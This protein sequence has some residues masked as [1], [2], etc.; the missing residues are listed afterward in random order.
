[1]LLATL[2]NVN[3]TQ[4]GCLSLVFPIGCFQAFSPSETSLSGTEVEFKV[5]EYSPLCQIKWFVKVRPDLQ[6]ESIFFIR[7]T[8]VEK[9]DEH[10]G[11]L[12]LL[13]VCNCVTRTEGAGCQRRLYFRM[14]I[15]TALV[16]AQTW[17]AFWGM[18]VCF[19]GRYKT[20]VPVCL[21]TKCYHT[22]NNRLCSAADSLYKSGANYWIPPCLHF[23]L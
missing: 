8:D 12:T 10:S 23:H 14:C 6:G 22:T 18:P 17:V 9:A 11:V 16:W 15:Q 1:M 20:R 21:D 13:L 3:P 7:S 2:S 19:F 4:G 5:S